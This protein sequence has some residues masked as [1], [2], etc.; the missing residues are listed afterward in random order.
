MTD[1]T[2]RR[3]DPR[4]SIDGDLTNR[5]TYHPPEPE[6]PEVYQLVRDVAHLLAVVVEAATYPSPERDLAV[7]RVEEAVMWANAAIARRGLSG[8]GV[9][10]ARDLFDHALTTLHTAKPGSTVV[11]D[12]GV[13]WSPVSAWERA[14]KDAHAI[15]TKD[16][17]DWVER[18]RGA[19]AALDKVVVT[20]A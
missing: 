10:G 2:E 3:F 7:T 6:Q 20:D 1:R 5:F 16:D 12:D 11:E 14:G 18:I 13:H 8:G 19:I 4:H 17:S 15:L 9:A